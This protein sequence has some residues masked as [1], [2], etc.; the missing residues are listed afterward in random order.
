MKK[1]KLI[2]RGLC[3]SMAVLMILSMVLSV[4]PLQ[5]NASATT[6]SNSSIIVNPEIS[7]NKVSGY[8]KIRFYD[9]NG[10]V[11][12]SSGKTVLTDEDGFFYAN[13]KDLSFD[14]HE[15][16]Y[17]TEKG[18]IKRKYS[19]V[20]LVIA[21]A[22]KNYTLTVDGK[23]NYTNLPKADESHAV[24]T[25]GD[26]EVWSDSV[27]FSGGN[28]G[29]GGHCLIIKLNF[30]KIDIFDNYNNSINT[31]I[32]YRRTSPDGNGK[33]TARG[34]ADMVLRCLETP[35]R[36]EEDEPD[37]DEIG[38]G[39][40]IWG[41]GSGEGEEP[42]PDDGSGT[43]ENPAPVISGSTPYVIVEEFSFAGGSNR[44][45]AGSSFNLNL[46]CRNTHNKVDLENIIMKVTAA[47]G[48]QL[49]NSSN[50]FYLSRLK[51]NASFEKELSISALPTAEA[52]SYNIT[53]AFT[54]E[55]IADGARQ[56]GEMTQDISIPVVQED[57]FS[58]D[59]I[60]NL[61]DVTVGEEIDVLSKYMNKSRGD[62]YN[63]I[64]TLEC[65]PSIICEEKII[66]GGNMTAGLSGEV[67]FT[68]NGTVPGTY[69]CTVIYT[70]ED[71]LGTAKETRVDFEVT[72]LEAPVYEWDQPMEDIPVDDGIIYDEFGNPIDP[73]AQPE[74]MTQQQKLLIGG[75]AAVAVLALLLVVRKLKKKKEF[76]DDD[77]NF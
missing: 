24:L 1:R 68:L 70:Y 67:D 36:P 27:S 13:D 2:T 10:E 39:D 59:P 73:M 71:S 51:K 12:K 74:G 17:D 56:K 21:Y 63:V 40:Q 61:V 76:E 55:Y 38:D 18:T 25:Y 28:N 52:K 43:P 14:K 42:L 23:G 47:E 9:N 65:D 29:E 19:Y 69:P 20:D 49:T 45:A 48:L 41:G 34:S 15:M 60:T 58:A 8:P 33:F 6:I 35:D 46:L 64:A 4:L 62:L 77:E 32:E 57:R 66:H 31:Y 7:M 5:A 54:Y 37:D 26:M 11:I 30:D 16:S 72:F 44:V 53:V 3:L 22:D 50:T 75:G